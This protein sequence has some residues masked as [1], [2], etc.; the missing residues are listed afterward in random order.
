MEK[1]SI[2]LWV[3]IGIN[4]L[5]LAFFAGVFAATQK[6][7]KEAKLTNGVIISRVLSPEMQAYNLE[8]AIITHIN[9]KP[10][11]NVEEVKSIMDNKSPRENISLKFQ[12][13]TG[14]THTFIFR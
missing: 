9:D 8:G 5:T 7:L 6:Q 3:S 2:E 11:Q 1:I 10:I 12:S 14:E 13:K 4:L